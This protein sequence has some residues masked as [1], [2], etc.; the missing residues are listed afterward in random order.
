MAGKREDLEIVIGAD[1]DGLAADLSRGAGMVKSFHADIARSAPKASDFGGKD[2][3]SGLFARTAIAAKSAGSSIRAAGLELAGFGAKVALTGGTLVGLEAGFASVSGALDQLK[4]SVAM[5]AELE[6]TTLAFDVMLGSAERATDLVSGLRRFA[7]E[8]PFNTRDVTAAGRALL[9]YGVTAD[10]IVPTVKMLGDVSAAFGKDLPLQQIT[11]EYGKIFSTQRVYA[12]ELLSMGIAGIPIYDELANVL[13]KSVAEVKELGEEGKIGRDDVTRAFLAMTG[14]GGRFFNMTQRQGQTLA[15]VWET[16]ADAF[17]LAKIKLGQIIIEEAGLKNVAKDLEA[18][19]NG[20]GGGMDTRGLRDGIRFAGDLAKGGAQIAYE[21][22]KAGAAMATIFGR[23]LDA[24]F[25]N[26]GRMFREG[27]EMIEGLKD[28]KFD[29]D[30]VIDFSITVGEVFID[31]FQAVAGMAL[32]IGKNVIKFVIAPILLAVSA[33][34]PI[35]EM[36]KSVVATV[37]AAQS[38]F[39]RAGLAVVDFVAHPPLFGG[40]S[41][42]AGA[43]RPATDA[44]INDQVAGSNKWARD[45]LEQLDRMTAAIKPNTDAMRDLKGLGAD[46]RERRAAEKRAEEWKADQQWGGD[47]KKSFMAHYTLF[48]SQR[49]GGIGANQF[50][51]PFDPMAGL[52]GAAVAYRREFDRTN[53]MS[54]MGGGMMGLAV[55]HDIPARGSDVR[56]MGDMRPGTAEAAKNLKKKYDPLA[57]GGSLMEHKADLDQLLERGKIDAATHALGWRDAVNEVAAG[58]HVGGPSKLADA[59]TVGSHEDARLLSNFMAGTQG[60]GTTDELL[61]QIRDALLIIKSSNGQMANQVP[62]VADFGGGGD[63]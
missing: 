60:Q 39:N 14:A 27:R 20:V 11:S 48:Q 53:A 44:V 9:A 57:A 58:L 50:F 1:L 19:A 43:D 37:P 52:M 62:K 7:A 4:S 32:E 40:G 41:R 54:A 29:G 31:A 18:F 13:G 49:Q 8:T 12:R 10:Q 25:P 46:I 5:A 16:T 47:A 56:L 38:A 21:F 42:N 26:A 33:M 35:F 2:D 15:G 45:L 3:H 55:N 59:A 23:Q 36:A 24:T 22:A 61:R 28:F 34:E 17:D 63:F 51:T 6:Q 30:K